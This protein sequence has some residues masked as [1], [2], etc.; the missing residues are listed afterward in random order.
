MPT[1]LFAAVLFSGAGITDA[2]DITTYCTVGL[3]ASHLYL[4]APYLGLR[5]RLYDGSMSEWSR[6]P[7]L[8]VVLGASPR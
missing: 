5:P 6:T 4:I 8:S 2:S 1:L 3:R 7:E